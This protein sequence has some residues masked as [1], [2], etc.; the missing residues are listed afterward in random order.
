M[1]HFMAAILFLFLIVFGLQTQYWKQFSC[2]QFSHGSY[3][4][5]ENKVGKLVGYCKLPPQDQ[6]LEC[7]RASDCEDVCNAITK[8]CD[9]FR[10]G[11]MS[12][13]NELGEPTQMIK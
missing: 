4:Y 11:S 2:E 12:V 9:Y 10:G 13:L 6:G 3:L 1:R 5:E 8:T 7:R